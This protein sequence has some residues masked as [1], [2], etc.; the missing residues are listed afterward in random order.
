MSRLFLFN[1]IWSYS[2]K[3]F[4]KKVITH[5][6]KFSKNSF[7]ENDK[8]TSWMMTLFIFKATL[9]SRYFSFFFFFIR[10][11]KFRYNSWQDSRISFCI[12]FFIISVITSMRILKIWN[13]EFCHALWEMI[14]I[15]VNEATS[16]F[17]RLISKNSQAKTTSLLYSIFVNK[18]FFFSHK[19]FSIFILC[20]F[21]DLRRAFL[22]KSENL[23]ISHCAY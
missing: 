4:I 20:N 23:R 15:F 22:V 14:L 13:S 16:C 6:A 3:K 9:T 17:I 8:L 1:V 2:E 7:I 19:K 18:F 11:Q 5:S 12:L 21:S 10:N